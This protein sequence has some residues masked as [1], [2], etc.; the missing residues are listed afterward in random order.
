MRVMDFTCTNLLTWVVDPHASRFEQQFYRVTLYDA[1]ATLPLVLGFGPVQ[2]STA[3]GLQMEL[4][5]PLSGN[6]RIQTS[7][8]LSNWNDL[9]NFPNLQIS[10]VRFRDGSAGAETRRFYRAVSP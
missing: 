7:T 10:P 6:Y 2:P 4:D 9:T 8:N 3:S 1:G 5:G